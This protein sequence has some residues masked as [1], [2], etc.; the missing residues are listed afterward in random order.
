[1]AQSGEGSPV[2]PLAP[3]AED[4]VPTTSPTAAEPAAVSDSDHDEAP[5]LRQV[6]SPSAAQDPAPHAHA[7]V[8]LG[9]GAAAGG[10][11]G[12]PSPP[13]SPDGLGRTTTSPS[14]FGRRS[15]GAGPTKLRMPGGLPPPILRP[16]EAEAQQ[17]AKDDQIAHL[18]AELAKLGVQCPVPKGKQPTGNLPKTVTW[19]DKEQ[20]ASD[21]EDAGVKDVQQRRAQ[22][23]KQAANRFADSPQDWPSFATRGPRRPPR[24]LVLFPDDYSPP[25]G[26]AQ[27]IRDLE[28]WHDPKGRLWPE[29]AITALE[30]NCGL[31]ARRHTHGEP[32]TV[33]LPLFVYSCAL[34]ENIVWAMWV[35][36]FPGG[37]WVQLLPAEARE[38]SALWQEQSGRGAP[39]DLGPSDSGD[40]VIRIEKQG[41]G[42]TSASVLN[43]IKVTLCSTA[44]AACGSEDSDQAVNVDGMDP[45]DF[46]PILV[47]GRV[48]VMPRQWPSTLHSN[49]GASSPSSARTV[50][51]EAEG[52]D[53]EGQTRTLVTAVQQATVA[54]PEPRS[55]PRAGCRSRRWRGLYL[56]IGPHLSQDAGL[57]RADTD[58]PTPCLPDREGGL[59][60]EC[61]GQQRIMLACFI[62]PPLRRKGCDADGGEQ[63]ATTS[64]S[65]YNGPSCPLTDCVLWLPPPAVILERDPGD[66]PT[67]YAA[68][69]DGNRAGSD[70]G[71]FMR[72]LS[73]NSYGSAD[74][75]PTR[76]GWRLIHQASCMVGYQADN[77]PMQS[78]Y[79]VGTM[80][81][82]EARRQSLAQSLRLN[83]PHVSD[84]FLTKFPTPGMLEYIYAHR[85]DETLSLSD[86]PD[87]G[88]HGAGNT[89][90]KF[91]VE[92]YCPDETAEN[93]IKKCL[94]KRNQQ[95]FDPAIFKEFQDLLYEKPKGTDPAISP[96]TP[97]LGMLDYRIRQLRAIL[98]LKTGFECPERRVDPTPE[99][100]GMPSPLQIA[101]CLDTQVAAEKLP[102]KH[103]SRERYVLA[104]SGMPYVLH[105]TP[106]SPVFE[107]EKEDSVR[108]CVPV[109]RCHAQYEDQ[110]FYHMNSAVRHKQAGKGPGLLVVR[111]NPKRKRKKEGRK[112]EKRFQPSNDW[113]CG[114]YK[115]RDAPETMG[116][117]LLA[118]ARVGA[119]TRLTPREH[120]DYYLRAWQVTFVMEP[121]DKSRSAKDALRTRAHQTVAW[122]C[123]AAEEWLESGG[124][125]GLLAPYSSSG[126]ACDKGLWVVRKYEYW[127]YE[128]HRP[129][130][131]PDP[132][133]D[134]EKQRRRFGLGVDS[135]HGKPPAGSPGGQPDREYDGLP[136]TAT[137]EVQ[138]R[139]LCA[140][141]LA[142]AEKVE[143][144]RP[145][146]VM[147]PEYYQQKKTPGPS[148]AAEEAAQAGPAAAVSAAAGSAPDE[149]EQKE[150]E[151]E[152]P[153]PDWKKITSDFLFELDL[154]TWMLH[155][156]RPVLWYIDRALAAM[157]PVV[158]SFHCVPAGQQVFYRG[159]KDTVLPREVYVKGAVILWA[160]FSSAS[161]DQGVAQ[162][163]AQG[164]QASV[165][166]LEGKSCRMVAPWSRFGREEEWLFQLNTLWVLGNLLSDQQQ[167]ILGQNVQLYE[168]S[169]V[170]E[171][172]VNNI[173]VRSALA[174]AEN[175]SS[176]AMVFTCL[177]ALATGGVLDLTLPED[178]QRRTAESWSHKV[179][180]E[181]DATASCPLET[182]ELWS[183]CCNN[184]AARQLYNAL[185]GH[186]DPQTSPEPR[187][188]AS[189]ATLRDTV[190]DYPTS[191]QRSVA[192][193]FQHDEVNDDNQKTAKII[194]WVTQLFNVIPQQV[195]LLSAHSQTR[196][197]SQ[198]SQT[199][200][201]TAKMSVR[202]NDMRWSFTAEIRGLPGKQGH[203]IG[204][205]GAQL[206]A[207][208]LERQVPLKSIN[209]RGNGLEDA[210]ATKL[211]RA[212]RC[213]KHVGQLTI[214]Q[215]GKFRPLNIIEED[216]V[217]EGNPHKG[218]AKEHAGPSEDAQRA[219][220]YAGTDEDPQRAKEN[221][222][223][224]EDA[225]A[226]LQHI[227]N[228][229]CWHNQGRLYPQQMD[230]VGP[231]WPTLAADALYD[232]AEIVFDWEA[233]F[234]TAQGKD[235]AVTFLRRLRMLVR[236][237]AAHPETSEAGDV[238]DKIRDKQYQKEVEKKLF[239]GKYPA[240][241]GAL[242][243]AVAAGSPAVV[244][245]LLRTQASL[246]EA[247]SYGET[248]QVK[249]MRRDPRL[250]RLLEHPAS[251]AIRATQPRPSDSLW[252]A[253]R[254]GLELAAL[255]YDKL[256]MIKQSRMNALRAISIASD[257]HDTPQ[258]DEERVDPDKK[259][260]NGHAFILELLDNLYCREY[261]ADPYLHCRYCGSC[262]WYVHVRTADRCTRCKRRARWP[263][264]HLH[265]R[266]ADLLKLSRK[267]DNLRLIPVSRV[268]VTLLCY[269]YLSR[270]YAEHNAQQEPPGS[271][272]SAAGMS[273]S[274]A[275]AEKVPQGARVFLSDEIRSA[276][277]VLLNT[278]GR[279]EAHRRAEARRK[280]Q[281][282]I[283]LLALTTSFSTLSK[284]QQD[285]DLATSF[286]VS[287]R[288]FEYYLGLARGS[289][290]V[291]PEPS[292]WAKWSRLGEHTVEARQHKEAAYVVT[293]RAR[294]SCRYEDIHW[295]TDLQWKEDPATCR[296]QVQRRSI[297]LPALSVFMVDSVEL[298][299][300]RK[301]VME[302]YFRQGG[303]LMETDTELRH[304]RDEILKQG[305]EAEKVLGV[306]SQDHSVAQDNYEQM[307]K[308]HQSWH[309]RRQ[310]KNEWD[311]EFDEYILEKNFR[312]ALVPVMPDGAQ[313]G[314]AGGGG[315][316]G[317]PGR[318]V[319]ESYNKLHDPR[320]VRR[321]RADQLRE[322]LAKVNGFV[323]YRIGIHPLKE[324]WCFGKAELGPLHREHALPYM[325]RPAC[326]LLHL[327]DRT[328]EYVRRG[329]RD[330]ASIPPKPDDPDWARPPHTSNRCRENQQE[331]PPEWAPIHPHSIIPCQLKVPLLERRN[332]AK[333]IT[334]NA[335]EIDR[336][337][338]VC[339]REKERDLE[340]DKLGRERPKA[341][342][343]YGNCNFTVTVSELQQVVQSTQACTS[344]G[345]P[346][347]FYLDLVRKLGVNENVS[348]FF[349][350][351]RAHSLAD[352]AAPPTAEV[353]KEGAKEPVTDELRER[354]KAQGRR[355]EIVCMLSELEEDHKKKTTRTVNALQKELDNLEEAIQR[356]D[357]GKEHLSKFK[358][359]TIDT[360]T[361]LPARMIKD[362]KPLYFKDV[363][364]KRARLRLN[365]LAK[366]NAFQ[367]ARLNYNNLTDKDTVDT[368]CTELYKWMQLVKKNPKW[369]GFRNKDETV[370]AFSMSL[371][372]LATTVCISQKGYFLTSGVDG[373]HN[374]LCE[375]SHLPV[376][377]L[378]APGVDFM[379]RLTARFE[380]NT[381]FTA[382]APKARQGADASPPPSPA[383]GRMQGCAQKEADPKWTAFRAGGEESFLHRVTVLYESIFRSAQRQGARI[384]SMLPLG[385]GVFLS[386]LEKQNEQLKDR[387]MEAYF[388][389][390]F[391]L[392]VREDWGFD[393]YFIS[394]GQPK[395]KKAAM[396]MLKECFSHSV[397]LP[398]Q[399]R[400]YL[401]ASVVLHDRDAKFLAQRMS[402][403][404]QSLVAFL[405]PSDPQA[406]VHGTLG[407]YWEVGRGINYVG[408]EDWAATSTGALGN[409][410]ISGTAL[411][412]D[413]VVL[414][415]QDG[416]YLH[417]SR[418]IG[419]AGVEAGAPTGMRQH[420]TMSG[421]IRA[422]SEVDR[423]CTGASW[424]EEVL[425]GVL[426]AVTS[427]RTHAGFHVHSV[428]DRTYGPF[429]DC[430]WQE[431]RRITFTRKRGDAA[432][433]GDRLSGKGSGDDHTEETFLL[434]RVSDG[435]HSE[436]KERLADLT[437]GDTR[438]RQQRSRVPSLAADSPAPKDLVAGRDA[439]AG[440]AAPH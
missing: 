202:H 3:G 4:S 322:T 139:D 276:A 187:T 308:E 207:E 157:R 398:L 288:E 216:V 35:P 179:R 296:K 279:Y 297:L 54:T 103:Q 270:P 180:K 93:L 122:R 9:A 77:V 404:G 338:E 260:T 188:P 372:A 375:K 193:D 125:T 62:R 12:G 401:H 184:A 189:R 130:H 421:Q 357:T 229:R 317:Y 199:L 81:Y 136:R 206:L 360:K 32:A 311:A 428:A 397:K 135:G 203:A 211:L 326:T 356:G 277:L 121:S 21:H 137:A 84:F 148:G 319:L 272:C 69:G 262:Y 286:H 76:A 41:T 347:F 380:G 40:V 213:N 49:S 221:E 115:A 411:G 151:A 200:Y 218:Q 24:K 209:L 412:L 336:Y 242:V 435:L 145:K 183:P 133:A 61:P 325:M 163:F 58:E 46:V 266:G 73:P 247:D 241:P 224:D 342:T 427:S 118:C 108:R 232:C 423:E 309:D 175:A 409:F 127:D 22:A 366:T 74:C 161:R 381:Y 129:R 164:K 159:L 303:S 217:S 327:C 236:F 248:P 384:L 425:P 124:D 205:E 226:R 33:A 252:C 50:T 13:K 253:K 307:F 75:G 418:V 305:D 171:K 178:A 88:D 190:Q 370:Y 235:H 45:I 27:A 166:T 11:L 99:D 362:G 240:F 300:S 430:E 243:A 197:T 359:E 259:I 415:L 169:E 97:V 64:D 314:A 230:E 316:E 258:D 388:R 250:Q 210:S 82:S 274:N 363:E 426:C 353:K 112:E 373:F 318:C 371:A 119:I 34:Y 123:P 150:K 177:D 420:R 254:F 354:Q 422:P 257:E 436:L 387:I 385:L 273:D 144:R 131:F 90:V 364:D 416:K 67:Y 392:L 212:L 292:F 181:Y 231:L 170:T 172:E 283:M 434:A 185:V 433:A 282:W 6:E 142:E 182:S 417:V 219:K 284:E 8:A 53:E 348:G 361:G 102:G 349:G 298:R 344:G 44:K 68:L 408:E 320:Q 107:P 321:K 268:A 386:Q 306:G 395:H 65:D 128:Q 337:C 48:P 414:L 80:R 51:S 293:L 174:Q 117:G 141:G 215:V 345:I 331:E 116:L 333:E 228:I 255:W 18:I 339:E 37:K 7:V 222:G 367:A 391:D 66:A 120:F 16:E 20:P 315:A 291:L 405:N 379:T 261:F 138:V 265:N 334:L 70:V 389:A 140:T 431:P 158:G 78:F 89:A 87:A 281:E 310:K 302:L 86:E 39:D 57:D 440:A 429:T 15:T 432:G 399:D 113:I 105:F 162:S 285:V 106:D 249:A 96:C 83:D 289:N 394:V 168:M 59:D 233:L 246:S 234:S 186:A 227:I 419:T 393:T 271:P 52:G 198:T 439:A 358:L 10:P 26:M 225:L 30:A 340:W 374:Q 237:A 304:W 438:P 329:R 192:D 36:F 132:V 396:Q 263:L 79:G 365:L 72:H 195:I 160:Q 294:G 126:R 299:E 355:N 350:P 25:V 369:Y 332:K 194:K 63:A 280:L 110:P 95:Q 153:P 239:T 377:F 155:E 220:E 341:S 104:L 146:M 173:N 14:Q 152:K 287:S 31:M 156:T 1:M 406:I 23:A 413:D 29:H 223:K 256:A 301:L 275:H 269:H 267:S 214:I 196:Q 346:L 244:R 424:R 390:Q 351:A 134:A 60:I 400:A 238:L 71:A 407:M 335:E 111:R 323:D 109:F 403:C 191:S 251:F 204:A 149:Q 376:V 264:Q 328:T 85:S 5:P 410:S 437:L 38:F 382:D 94:A 143:V 208:I 114:T 47:D 278:G 324:Y 313:A 378:S 101:H 402:Q 295:I 165:F 167:E 245:S 42:S 19:D 154:G 147:Y 92:R 2:S 368:A 91:Q 330:R 17:K 28:R 56:Y 201:W 312:Q 98:L 176:A 343:V 383:G 290:F 100:R 43:T 55:S 352:L